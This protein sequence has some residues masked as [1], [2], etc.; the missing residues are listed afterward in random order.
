MWSG[1]KNPVSR[2]QNK[3]SARSESLFFR[4]GKNHQSVYPKDL[5]DNPYTFVMHH[6]RFDRR[7]K[8]GEKN[9]ERA[10]SRKEISDTELAGH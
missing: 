10:H 9:Y 6:A 1:S 4:C 7:D 5:R 2:Q 3:Q 8:A